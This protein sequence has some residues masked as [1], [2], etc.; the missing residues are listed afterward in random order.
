MAETILEAVT[1]YARA[2][3]AGDLAGT[4]GAYSDDVV[5][6][7][8]GAHALSGTHRGKPAALAAL[9]EFSRRTA[10][11]QP[12]IIDV[13]AGAARAVIVVRERLGPEGAPTERVLVYRVMDG[14][15]A[16]CWVH[17]TDPDLIDRLVGQAPL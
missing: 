6:H 13:M 14:L 8:G 17:D 15:L 10:R 5:L 16:E 4:V 9:A 2:W 11:G 12:E 1:R 3:A 7:W